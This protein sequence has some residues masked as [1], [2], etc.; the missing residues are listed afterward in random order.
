MPFWHGPHCNLW[1]SSVWPSHTRPGRRGASA[2]TSFKRAAAAVSDVLSNTMRTSLLVWCTVPKPVGRIGSCPS[3]G[4]G[5]FPLHWTPAGGAD[6]ESPIPGLVENS[7]PPGCPPPPDNPINTVEASPP[8]SPP[9]ALA[10]PD[11]PRPPPWTEAVP[12]GF[13]PA[14]W[15]EDNKSS[16][17]AAV[18]WED[19][20]FYR[21]LSRYLLVR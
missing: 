13:D 1:L 12:G 11:P 7:L 5:L 3:V 15:W 21:R 10:L 4:E 19:F 17:F 14:Q 6:V 9:V 16:G 8:P 18:A 20:A 2:H